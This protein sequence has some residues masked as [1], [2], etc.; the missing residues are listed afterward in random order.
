MYYVDR[1]VDGDIN[2]YGDID[3]C[4]DGYVDGYVDDYVD[5]YVIQY[6]D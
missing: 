4:I 1:Y 2:N 5:R 6:V 3:E